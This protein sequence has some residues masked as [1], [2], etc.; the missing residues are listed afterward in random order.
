MS[1]NPNYYLF[2]KPHL[3]G[4]IDHQGKVLDEEISQL[5][6][7]SL[8]TIAEDDLVESLVQKYV[9][10]PIIFNEGDIEVEQEDV[11]IDV[12]HD[13]MRL[14]STPGPHFIN[15]YKFVYHIPFQG[16][17][18]LFQYENAI[19]PMRIP[20][21]KV[22]GRYLIIEAEVE[23]PE[24]DN[25]DAHMQGDFNLIK[26]FVDQTNEDIKPFNDGLEA[27]IRRGVASRKEKLA[28]AG[29]YLASSKFKVRQKSG[30]TFPTTEVARRESISITTTSTAS[31]RKPEPTLPI[32]EYNHILEI[33]KHHTLTMERSPST[34]KNMGEEEIRDTLLAQLNGHYKGKATAEAFNKSGKTDILVRD[35]D[36]NIFIGECKIWGGGDLF[37]KTIDQLLGYTAWRDT[38]TSLIIFNRNK[39]LSAVLAQIPDLV[40]QHPNFVRDLEGGDETDFRYVLHHNDDKSRELYMTVLIVE[41]PA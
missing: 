5:N 30:T 12:S 25:P 32:A 26:Q 23:N 10:N 11:K 39:D 3:R 16:D 2:R 37:L 9:L 20:Y 6:S 14:W 40:H 15:G 24:R 28:S 38:K 4:V 19:F 1:R 17:G 33:I 22:Q 29:N 21:G 35:N 27:R 34:Y 41:V 31:G 36:K 18:E 13:G 7:D 8:K